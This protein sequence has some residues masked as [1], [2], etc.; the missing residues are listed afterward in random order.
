MR[1]NK[2]RQSSDLM[3]PELGGFEGD[4]VVLVT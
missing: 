1:N 2:G 3:M 4:E